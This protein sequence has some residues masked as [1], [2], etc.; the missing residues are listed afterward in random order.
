MKNDPHELSER[1]KLILKAIVDAHIEGG[2]P[3]GSKYILESHR[4]ACSSATIRNEM[5]ELEEMGYLEQPH[6]SS[7]RV[8]SELGYRFYVDSL[9]DHY[10]MTAREVVQINNL[11]KIKMEELDQIL[12]TASKL[13]SSLTNY[14]GIAIRPKATSVSFERYE[15]VYIDPHNLLLIMM[16][17]TALV[18][19]K[20]IRCDE[21]VDPE[22]V[23]ALGRTLNENM[24]GCTAG[25]VTLSMMMK[26][27]A[28]MGNRQEP[29]NTALKTIYKV[30]GELDGGELKLS[31]LNRLLQYP[32]YS[33]QEQL[34]ELIGALES[35]DEIL[36]LVGESEKKSGDEDRVKVVLGSESSVKVMNQSAIVYKQIKKDGRTVGAIGIIGP[37]RMDYAKVLATIDSLGGNIANLLDGG[38][39]PQLTD[40]GKT[41]D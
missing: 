13:A 34:G 10:A 1:K 37:L 31:G 30:A 12:D 11:L 5:A 2:E 20:N 40:G 28:D 8:P 26:M 27:E 32:E 17:G 41:D 36:N 19:T 25:D 38:D 4:L 16:N 39:K 14:T 7:G 23:A 3:V 18:K 24:S 9:I 35:K 22:T 15:T 29:L 21:P 6:T 33:D